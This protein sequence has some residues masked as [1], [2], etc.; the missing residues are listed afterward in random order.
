MTIPDF[1]RYD[2]YVDQHFYAWVEEL[3]VLCAEPTLAG[4]GVGIERGVELVLSLLEPL[5]A[6]TEVVPIEGAPPVV[7]AELGRGDRTLLLYNHYDVQPPEPLDLWDSPPYAGDVRDGNFYARGV[8]DDRGD[9]ISRI[10]AIRAYQ[11][12][13]GDLR[14]RLRW[15]V[16]GEEEVGSPNLE[17]AIRANSQKLEA[18]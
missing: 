12:T 10:F 13:M 1:S 15:F 18:D 16:E 2:A 5:G 3:R 6:R 7:L 8:A 4:Q 17:P 14:L 11:A 9:F